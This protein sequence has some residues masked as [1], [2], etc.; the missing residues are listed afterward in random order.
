MWINNLTPPDGVRLE[1]AG[2]V[3]VQPDPR[4][5]RRQVADIT[6]EGCAVLEQLDRQ[7]SDFFSRVIGQF[8]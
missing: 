2:L 4:D 5:K 7:Q 3:S 6:A 1:K 8:K